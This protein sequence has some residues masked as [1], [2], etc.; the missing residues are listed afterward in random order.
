MDEL[1]KKQMAELAADAVITGR[2]EWVASPEG[3]LRYLIALA[4]EYKRQLEARRTGGRSRSDA[5]LAAAK[6]N[7]EKAKLV[8]DS[9]SSS[10]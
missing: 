3:G 7:I 2:Y 9:R 5:K 1:S 10:E 8:V 6:K 4:T